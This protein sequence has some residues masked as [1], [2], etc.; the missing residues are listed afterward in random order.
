M[1]AYS[2]GWPWPARVI[3]KERLERMPAAFQREGWMRAAPLGDSSAG[4]L[5]IAMV[6]STGQPSAAAQAKAAWSSNS[7]R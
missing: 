6:I 5:W 4:T 1:A 3:A 7:R 2:E